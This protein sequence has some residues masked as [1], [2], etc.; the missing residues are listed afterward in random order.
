M[1]AVRRERDC[2]ASQRPKGRS[3]FT[4]QSAGRGNIFPDASLLSSILEEIYRIS[5]FK[6]CK[7]VACR[8]YLSAVKKTP[9]FR[10][11]FLIKLDSYELAIDDGSYHC[12][13]GSF[14]SSQVEW[15]VVSI[16]LVH[17]FKAQ[18][19]AVENISPGSNRA[20]L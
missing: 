16:T 18:V 19:S 20:T 17:Y 11:A 13:R 9:P 10:R 1:R 7:R 4:F 12:N 3:P 6:P 15:E 14:A 5:Y 8:D 2:A